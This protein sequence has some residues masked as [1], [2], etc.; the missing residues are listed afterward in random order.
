VTSIRESLKR[1][2]SDEKDDCECRDSSK[3]W[4][5]NL[6]RHDNDIYEKNDVL[7]LL[8]SMIYAYWIFCNDYLKMLRFAFNLIDKN[9]HFVM[10]RLTIIFKFRWNLRSLKV[11]QFH[12]FEQK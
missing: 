11:R 8:S 10:L 5:A 2:R 3:V 7:F 1:K 6:E 4:K 12:W 9:I